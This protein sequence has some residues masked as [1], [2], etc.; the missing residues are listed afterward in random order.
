M[1][2]TSAT[3]L[4]MGSMIGS[5]IFIVSA[6]IARLSDSPV[7]LIGAWLLTGFLTI[8]GALAYGELA[9]M[10][11]PRRRPV[12]LP[13]RR[14]G[15]ALG[16]SLRLDALPGSAD[17]HHR[18]RGHRFRQV[19]RHLL[20]VRLVDALA[21]THC[22]RAAYSHRAHG[23]GQ[24]GCR[25]QHAESRRHPGGDFSL[26]PQHLWGT[27]RRPGAEHLHHR[28]DSGAAGARVARSFCRTQ[29]PGYR[30][31]LWGELLAQCGLARAASGAGGEWEVRSRWSAP[32]PFWRWRRWARCFLP[33]PGTTSPSP[34][35]RYAIPSAICR[36][37]WPWE[38]ER[39][40]CSTCWPTLFI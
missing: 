17:R 28:Q 7:L 29:C 24:Y 39:S 13:A 14:T 34:R 5:G 38:P 32:S 1:G 23:A 33:T 9:A 11:P 18:R 21:P 31:Q 15:T 8:T 19:S 20:S 35:P 26:R 3:T 36:W 40:R 10:M 12:C 30:R 25:A 4:V 6:E 37:R 16:I 2:L 27:H 22:P